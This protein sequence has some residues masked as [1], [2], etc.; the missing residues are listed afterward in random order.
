MTN[1]DEEVEK[2]EPSYTVGENVN[3]CNPCGKRYESFSKKL[4]PELHMAQQFY[5][6]VYIQKYEKHK[7]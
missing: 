6:L 4:K 3:W 1:V 2:M 5:A 7:F